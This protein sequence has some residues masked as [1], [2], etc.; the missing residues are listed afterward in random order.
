[1]SD[2]PKLE[3][4]PFCGS[5]AKINTRPSDPTERFIRCGNDDCAVISATYYIKPNALDPTPLLVDRWN[6]RA[7]SAPHEHVWTAT[8]L[9]RRICKITGCLAVEHATWKRGESMSDGEL[10]ARG[11]ITRA[12]IY[13]AGSSDP[14][15][16][17]RALAEDKWNQKNIVIMRAELDRRAKERDA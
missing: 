11:S 12:T 13:I 17:N 5:E 14:K 9:P 7:T 3:P 10:L 4:C 1:M 8:A 15:E 2:D 6:R 16:E